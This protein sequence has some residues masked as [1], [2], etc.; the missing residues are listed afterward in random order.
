MDLQNEIIKSFTLENY[1]RNEKWKHDD[2]NREESDGHS[3]VNFVI[4]VGVLQLDDVHSFK[5]FKIGPHKMISVD[6][7]GN[8]KAEK[9]NVEDKHKHRN[10]KLSL[11]VL[12]LFKAELT[13]ES[14]KHVKNYSPI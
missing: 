1:E 4:T 12:V 9:Q 5:S 2:A 7:H 11:W 6:E 14:I 3:S 13:V 8:Q 10:E